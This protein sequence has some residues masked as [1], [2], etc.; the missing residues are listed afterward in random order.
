MK[1][2]LNII[3]FLT[4]ISFAAF[5]GGCDK[6]SP[7][8]LVNSSQSE[9]D[10]VVYETI[11]KNPTDEIYS[12]GADT[13]GVSDNLTR[14]S[15]V[16]VVSGTKISDN[17]Q[18]LKLSTAQAVFFDR[19]MPVRANGNLIGYQTQL[20]GEVKFN[21]VRALTVPFKVKFRNAQNIIQ[22]S[23]LGFYHL[24]YS[25]RAA[26]FHPFNYK[27]NSI[28]SFEFNPFIGKIN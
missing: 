2:Y 25:G 14:Y 24:L 26:S 8:E 5:I 22:D 23:T 3:Y 7:T 18:T 1:T 19:A 10:P 16:V 15:N 6:P 21:G 12:N 11:A 27:Y 9:D 4:A 17:S 13:T 28:V 20:L